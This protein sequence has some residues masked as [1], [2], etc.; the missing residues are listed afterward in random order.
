M[1]KYTERL[2]KEWR[3]YGKIIISVD[4]DSTLCYW[5]T[6]NNQGDISRVIK[7]LQLAHET[8]AYITVFTASD[9]DKFSEIQ[10]HCEQIK[11]PIDS[12]NTNAI[13]LPYGNHGKIYYNINL[14]DRSGL[15]EALNMLEDAMYIIRG[16]KANQLTK[17]ESI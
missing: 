15:I 6:I 4:Y 8:G 14:C 2:V 7:L 11:V 16:D 13:P 3:Q 17:G 12:I 1:D 10:K 9:V 5:P